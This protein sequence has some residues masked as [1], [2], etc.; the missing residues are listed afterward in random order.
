MT[1]P[2]K[3]RCWDKNWRYYNSA[4]TDVRRTWNRILRQMKDSESLKQSANVKPLKARK[5]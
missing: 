1:D 4:D 5:A 2:T 3:A